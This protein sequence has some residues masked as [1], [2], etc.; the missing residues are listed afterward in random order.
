[1]K[2]IGIIGAMET[3]V[4]LLKQLAKKNGRVKEKVAGGLIFVEGKINGVP[5]VIVKSGVGKVNAALCAQRLILQFKVTHIINTGIAG[6]IK[7][8]LKVF[9]F[10]VSSDAVYHDMDATPWGYKP[11]EIPQMNRI[12]FPADEA[13][14]QA[15][16][17]AF[18]DADNE[19]FFTGHRVITG[20][21]ASGDQFISGEDVKKRIV[22][23]C[24]P[25]CVEMEGAAI[26]HACFVSGIPYLIL[27]CISDMADDSKETTDL[28][29]ESVAAELSAKLVVTLLNDF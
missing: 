24:D 22:E 21:I 29:N 5:I 18:T 7:H 28:F 3:E 2:K 8:G 27:R 1:M 26:A 17:A 15:A 12:S 19:E 25:A 4:A 16:Q 13:L 10:V 11:M 23:I 9:D 14:L 6:A 20:R